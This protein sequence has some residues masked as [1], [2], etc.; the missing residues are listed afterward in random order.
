M[1]ANPVFTLT[2]TGARLSLRVTPN[3]RHTAIEGIETRADGSTA[4][5][6]RVAA[7]PDKGAANTAVIALL[8]KAL[9]L[10]RTS[11]SIVS[12]STA[13]SKILAIAASPSALDQALAR[14][15]PR[16]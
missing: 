11:L 15:T 13:R 12:G 1:S 16:N 10:P 2:G 3:A 9:N 6:I 8:A 5:R 7:P 4:L 14:L